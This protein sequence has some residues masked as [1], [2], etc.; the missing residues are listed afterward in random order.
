MRVTEVYVQ[1]DDD[2]LFTGSD[3]GGM[4][5]ADDASSGDHLLHF[6]YYMNAEPDEP[7]LG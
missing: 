4:H 3:Y 2:D 1:W 5:P 7:V 6:C